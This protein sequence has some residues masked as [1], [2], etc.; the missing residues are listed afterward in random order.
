[1]MFSLGSI[2]ERSEKK[3]QFRGLSPARSFGLVRRAG[4]GAF[5]NEIRCPA[6]RQRRKFFP[7]RLAAAS[8]RPA[9]VQ[10]ILSHG[11]LPWHLE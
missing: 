3:T 7:R 4:A 6:E 9:G 2:D 1:M 8:K 11:R 5:Q 10:K